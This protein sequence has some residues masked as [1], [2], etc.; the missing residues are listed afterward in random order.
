MSFRKHLFNCLGLIVLLQSYCVLVPT[1]SAGVVYSEAVNGQLSSDSNNPTNLGIFTLGVNSVSGSV[2]FI[3][4]G[5]SN[6][7]A[8]IFTFRIEAG[9]VLQSIILASYSSRRTIEGGTEPAPGN[10]FL[11]IDDSAVFG[12]T[13]EEINAGNPP[14]LS[15]ILGASVVGDL[16]PNRVGTDILSVLASSA[17]NN[18]SPPRSFS[19]PLPA[20]SYSIYIQETGPLS[21]YSLNFNVVAVPEPSSL[22]LFG[23]GASVATAVRYRRRNRAQ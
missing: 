21:T 19:V 6:D 18:T 13:K 14:D 4:P 3:G 8:D 20:G 11:A 7:T 12:Y 23:I 22:V 16:N 15:R 5:G 17:T 10:M 2:N 1:C 9:T